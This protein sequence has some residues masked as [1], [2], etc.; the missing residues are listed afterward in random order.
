MDVSQN[1]AAPPVLNVPQLYIHTCFFG[2]RVSNKKAGGRRHIISAGRFPAED[3]GAWYGLWNKQHVAGPGITF[4]GSVFRL[5][6]SH[7]NLCTTRQAEMSSE[8]KQMRILYTE[9]RIMFQQIAKACG[10]LRVSE[11]TPPP[12]GRDSL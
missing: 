12:Q 9:L 10:E 5:V 2:L 1:A 3:T 7:N 6:A 8:F 11:E 4:D